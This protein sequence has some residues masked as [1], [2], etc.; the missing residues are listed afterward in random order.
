VGDRVAFELT[1]T[2]RGPDAAR[3]VVMQDVPPAT[4]ALAGLRSTGVSRPRLVRGN[5]VWRLGTIAPGAS[6][7]VRGSV[8][9]EA[10][11]PGLHHNKVLATAVNANLARDAADTRL[12]QRRP[13]TPPVT[14]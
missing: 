11:S 12:L 3:D 5:A 8:V 4:L 2:N 10:G 14:G 9:L 6:R 7:T 1:V 13:V